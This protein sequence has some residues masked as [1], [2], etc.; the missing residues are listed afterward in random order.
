MTLL[1]GERDA[2]DPEISLVMYWAL[3]LCAQGL[4]PCN[5]NALPAYHSLESLIALRWIGFEYHHY[6]C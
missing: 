3:I 4:K 2:E 1:P 6:N 5:G